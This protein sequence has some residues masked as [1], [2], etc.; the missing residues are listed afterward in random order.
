MRDMISNMIR[1]ESDF[2]TKNTQIFLRDLLDHSTRIIDTVET[3]RDL[4]SG[5]MDVY[6]S[7]A[8][9]RMNEVMKV[10]TIMSSIFIPVTFVAGVYGMN[11]DVMPELRSTYGYA[12]V[13]GI[14]L[15]IMI[16]Q[17]IYFKRRKWF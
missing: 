4:L 16:G 5:I 17:I 3:Y 1:S 12:I 7:N 14:M 9:N 2:I 11:F 8:S 13:W 10:L 15:A 6:L